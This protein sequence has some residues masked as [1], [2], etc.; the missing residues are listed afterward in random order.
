M[1][2]APIAPAPIEDTVTNTPMMAPTVI[3][4]IF[5]LLPLGKKLGLS[6]TH[7]RIFALNKSDAAVSKTEMPIEMLIKWLKFFETGPIYLRARIENIAVVRL[8]AQR[9][10][11]ISQRMLPWSLCAAVPKPLVMAAKAK[12]VPTAVVGATPKRMVSS[13]V[14]SEPP[15]T[16]VIPTKRPT[17]APEII[18]C[19]ESIKNWIMMF[20]SLA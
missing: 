12:S 3:V 1:S 5:K 10:R 9:R 11:T 4:A 2:V 19:E 18:N 15:P 14:M 13:G 20:T 6:C 8:P 17:S 7:F 16:P